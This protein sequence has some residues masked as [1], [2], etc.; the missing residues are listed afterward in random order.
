VIS[1][2]EHQRMT[3]NNT[4]WRTTISWILDADTVWSRNVWLT[5][6]R[7]R[8]VHK[9]SHRTAAPP[10]DTERS[11]LSN[12]QLEFCDSFLTCR[13]QNPKFQRKCAFRC[14]WLPLTFHWPRLVRDS[15]P[16]VKDSLSCIQKACYLHSGH[17][18]ISRFPP[19]KRPHGWISSFLHTIGFETI[20]LQLILFNEHSRTPVKGRNYTVLFFLWLNSPLGA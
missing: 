8:F 18:S 17:V 10:F 15:L 19:L 4:V 2:A 7:R 9:S 1:S 11:R 20:Q 13:T 16:C 5:G 14:N 12:L 3:N 6:R